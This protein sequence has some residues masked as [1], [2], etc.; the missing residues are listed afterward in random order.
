MAEPQQQTPQ[1]IFTGEPPVFSTTGRSNPFI[2]PADGGD[3]SKPALPGFS[4]YT[5]SG[6]MPPLLTQPSAAVFPQETVVRQVLQTATNPKSQDAE[7]LLK[8]WA[9]A[10]LLPETSTIRGL[11]GREKQRL[12]LE[13]LQATDRALQA[14]IHFLEDQSILRTV[15]PGLQ[16]P[17]DLHSQKTRQTF[18]WVLRTLHTTCKS[19]QKQYTQQK[20][21]LTR[22]LFQALKTPLK[23]LEPVVMP[24]RI[25]RRRLL[26]VLKGIELLK[27]TVEQHPEF[28]AYDPMTD[29]ALVSNLP[30]RISYPQFWGELLR[31]YRLL[32]Q[33]VQALEARKK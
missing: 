25:A 10:V 13:E 4:R 18:L 15:A 6:T 3:T 33:Q 7:R 21:S 24:G 32:M 26:D 19:V 5:A 27:D 17:A 8:S 11:I 20:L 31:V 28:L 2:L 23:L 30:V 9:T 1:S 22:Q 14:A 12:M 16:L 29:V